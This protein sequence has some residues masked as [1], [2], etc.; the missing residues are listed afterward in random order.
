[1]GGGYV[2]SRR[3]QRIV[4]VFLLPEQERHGGLA[5]E[6][7]PREVSRENAAAGTAHA[8]MRSLFGEMKASKGTQGPRGVWSGGGLR[9]KCCGWSTGDEGVPAEWGHEE[10]VRMAWRASRGV[11]EA[12][13]AAREAEG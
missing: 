5:P 2:S 13:E 4:L 3:R 7:S 1:M 6:A 10:G 11:G 12:I 9:T 8:V